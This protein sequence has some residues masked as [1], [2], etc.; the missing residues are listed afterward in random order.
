MKLFHHEKAKTVIIVGCGALGT[1]LAEA[2]SQKN[3]FIT[4][5]DCSKNALEAL[6]EHCYDDCVEGNGADTGILRQAQI[7]A[8]D[9]FYAVTGDD[10]TNLMA[11]QIAKTCFGVRQVFVRVDDCTKESV[12][13]GMGMVIL[14]APLL[15]CREFLKTAEEETDT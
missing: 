13:S 14:S 15:L 12:Y 5:I 8:C 6:P 3:N 1:A 11:A 10:N 7:H 4:L 2:L 9:Q